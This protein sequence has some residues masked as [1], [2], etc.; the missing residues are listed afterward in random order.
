MQ[1]LSTKLSGFL[2]ALSE[3]IRSKADLLYGTHAKLNVYQNTLQE[4][5]DPVFRSM[6]E[7][8]HEKQVDY[9]TFL[10]KQLN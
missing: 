7:T 5:Y 6:K 9:M 2:F 3:K 8:T 10:L 1:E 4:K